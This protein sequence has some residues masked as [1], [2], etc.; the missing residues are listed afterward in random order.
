MALIPSEQPSQVS[1]QAFLGQYGIQKYLVNSFATKSEAFIEVGQPDKS[2]PFYADVFEKG[3]SLMSLPKGF[4]KTQW[5]GVGEKIL[6]WKN[7]KPFISRTKSGDGY[8]YLFSSPLQKEFGDFAEHALFVPT[9]FKMAYLSSKADR[10]AYNF[11]EGSIHF[12]M[13]NAPK[14]A[15]YKLKSGSLEL[16]P[17]QSARGKTLVLTLPKSSELQDNQLLSSG[18][19]NVEIDGKVEKVIA[20]NHGR[21]ES[22]MDFY[23]SD[24][25][26]RAF[27]GNKNIQVYEGFRDGDFLDAFRESLLEKSYWKQFIIAALVFLLLEILLTRFWRNA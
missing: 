26:R 18:L 2:S 9:M 12:Y 23:T 7:D 21:E 6:G 24:E 22:F 13:P 8:I 25:L 16:I 19:Y 11:S 5:T 1:L 20:L 17:S 4:P 3:N 27:A 15:V 14:N 10:L